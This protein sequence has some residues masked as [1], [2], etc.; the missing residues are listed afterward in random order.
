MDIVVVIYGWR[1]AGSRSHAA[2]LI[3]L[4]RLAMTTRGSAP[5]KKKKNPWD[6]IWWWRVVV[7][8]DVCVVWRCISP[9]PS[10]RLIVHGLS[11]L[12]HPVQPAIYTRSI[13][14]EKYKTAQITIFYL[15]LNIVHCFRTLVAPVAE[16]SSTYVY[17]YYTHFTYN[18]L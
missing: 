15:P 16:Q 17:S 4:L 18:S 11:A 6:G 2:R 1:F 14:P 8:V 7:V 13:H 9:A 12:I 5:Q 10:P 3:V